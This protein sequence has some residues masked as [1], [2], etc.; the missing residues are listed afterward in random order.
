MTQEALTQSFGP[1]FVLDMEDPAFVKDPYPTYKWLREEA[2]AYRW[3]SR[4]DAIVVSRH[5]DVKAAVTDRRFSNDYRLWEFSREAQWPPE[6]AEYKRIQDNG[7]FSLPDADHIRVRKLVSGAFT[8]RAADRMKGEIQRAVDEIIAEV[9][10]G[11]TFNIRDITEPLP[12]RVISD[13][14]KIPEGLR[15]EFRAYGLAAIRSSILFNDPQEVFRLIAPM[16]R[17]I[18]MLR[19]VIA[20]RAKDLQ[21][22]DLLSTLISARDGG[23]KLNEDELISLVQA[24]IVAGSDTT[25]HAATWGMYS[26]LRHPDQLARLRAEPGLL[27]NAVEE[28]LRYDLFGKGGVPKFAKEEM[29]F[30]GTKV[31]KGQMVIP[32]I[33]A[34]L[35]DEKVFPEPEKFDI[36]RDVSQTIAFSAGQHFCLGAGLARAELDVVIGTLVQRFPKMKLIGEAEIAPHPIMRSI[37]RLQVSVS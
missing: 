21:S 35:H 22:D 33:P 37:E 2:P 27:R 8:P 9:V 11:D 1:H 26:L 36:R 15:A 25:V 24:L 14:L 23:S 28:T 4:G 18:G 19:E 16:P 13:M 34:A 31:R 6:H 30:V 12:M 32:F 29:E 5:E 20:D 7:L 10:T 17:W 3:A